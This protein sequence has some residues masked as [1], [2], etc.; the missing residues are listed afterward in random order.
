V[1]RDLQRI[2]D[3]IGGRLQRAAAI[4]DPQLRLQVYSPHYGPVDDVRLASILHREAP[5][6]AREWVESLGIAAASQPVRLPA[7]DELGLMPRVCAPIRFQDVHLG[8]LWLIDGDGD[9]GI[10]DDQ[11]GEV[12]DAADRAAVVMY[13]AGLLEQL[14]RGQERE[15]LRDLLSGDDALASHAAAQLIERDLFTRNARPIAIVIRPVPGAD[16]TIGEHE[17]VTLDAVLESA[18]GRVSSRHAL[19]LVRPDHGVLV[20]AGNDPAV[21]PTGAVTLARDLAATVR[22]KLGG[23]RRIVAGVGD[24]QE[25]LHRTELSYRQ[26]VRATH[27]VEIVPSFGDVASWSALG[28]YRTLSLLPKDDLSAQAIHPG[29]LQLLD[30]PAHAALVHSL[31]SYLDRAGDAKATSDHLQIHRT[32]LYYRLGRV[33]EL[34][35]VDLKNGDDRLAL[36][37]G[38]KTARLAG[39]W[40]GLAAEP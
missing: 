36:H 29:L 33:E 3:E 13:R 9:G 7:N 10:H 32:S 31:E 6:D 39:L 15:L 28:I 16:E 25:D 27:V 19:Q 37:L 30:D 12:Q 1:A 35:Q 40:A 14:E 24:A 2:V 11:I 23:Q 26:A 4:D 20:V 38:L 34:A 5:S 18:R 22:S 17:R 8:Y 21:T